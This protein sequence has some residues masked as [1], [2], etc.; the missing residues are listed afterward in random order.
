MVKS[1]ILF[2][3]AFALLGGAAWANEKFYCGVDQI[4]LTDEMILVHLEDGV[5]EIDSLLADQGGLYF[6]V[7]GLRSIE[8]RRP[9]DPR[10]ICERPY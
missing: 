8:T 10:N 3:V 2:F 1:A 7:D 5:Y 4:E 6:T 9:V